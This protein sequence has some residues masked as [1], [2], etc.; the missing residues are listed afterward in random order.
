MKTN[1]LIGFFVLHFN[2]A[3]VN[4]VIRDTRVSGY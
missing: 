3:G 4:I 2:A 1:Y